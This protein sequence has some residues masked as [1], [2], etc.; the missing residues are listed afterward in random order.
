MAR[1]LA[2][3]SVFEAVDKI[4]GP[5]KTMRASIKGF[6]KD[7]NRAGAG[8]SS[9]VSRIGGVVSAVKA[10][11]A[12]GAVAIAAKSLVKAAMGVENA[13]A[14]F[15]PLTGSV[16]SARAV[17]D[18]LNKTAAKTPFQ[19]EQLADSANT[20]LGFGAATEETLIP[21][22]R[23][24]GDTAGG[25]ADRLR[26]IA[27]AFSQIKAAGRASMQDINQLINNGVPILGELAEMWGVTVGEAR[28][29]VSQGRATADEI[30]KAFKR[31]T[32][33]GGRFYRGMEIASQTTSG[34]FSTL[35]DNITLTMAALGNSLLPTVK[36]VAQSLIDVAQKIREWV[37]ANKELIQQR[38][39]GVLGAIAA[40]GKTVWNIFSGV[41]Q[42]IAKLQT[43]TGGA[44]IP[45]LLSAVVAYKAITTAVSIYKG[46]QMALTSAQQAGT[47]ATLGLNAAMKANPIGLII[48]AVTALIMII[49]LLIANW[50][51]I[52]EKV[53]EFVQS[54]LTVLNGLWN[55]I[56]TGFKTA[57]DF[58]KKIF[59]TF[60]DVFLTIYGSIAKT[61]LKGASILG[62]IIGINTEGL[63]KT[64]SAITKTQQAVR[65]NSF[66]GDIQKKNTSISSNISPQSAIIERK[67]TRN[68]KVEVEFSGQIP[69]G[70][71][72]RQSGRG[73][74]DISI[75]TGRVRLG[76]AY[77]Q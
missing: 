66:I 15:Q 44:F 77:V 24:L 46:V 2:I 27:L 12:G 26:G 75:N 68:A 56:K 1:K 9:T 18:A 54:A 6:A 76:G 16:E 33:E 23:M 49:S 67:E 21:T 41:Y 60:A 48:T 69:A 36:S 17:V 73:A 13:I 4:T 7:T 25:N 11:V 74:P 47:I 38:V 19:F 59:F 61:V 28:E 8:L 45:A 22:L 30:E 55:G 31:M 39:E 58:V 70:T 62:K 52:K 51:K 3:Y 34:V 57:F 65:E 5:V 50:D 40:V 53:K 29:M 64:I 20:L 42:I 35:K 43:F 63:D 72:I 71:K 37:I 10:A 14:A 32:S